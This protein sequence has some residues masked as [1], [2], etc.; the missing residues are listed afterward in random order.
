MFYKIY[1]YSIYGLEKSLK[2]F[3]DR[4]MDSIINNLDPEE[5]DRVMV[6]RHI[7]ELDMDEVYIYKKLEKQNVRKRKK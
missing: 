5:Y 4:I 7:I 3:D 1:I 6:V 2:V